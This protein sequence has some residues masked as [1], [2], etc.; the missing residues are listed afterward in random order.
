MSGRRFA[1]LC[2]ALAD[3]AHKLG[4][5]PSDDLLYNNL[6]SLF[7]E[8]EQL[9]EPVLTASMAVQAERLVEGIIEDIRLHTGDVSWLPLSKIHS[10]W[11]LTYLA[12]GPNGH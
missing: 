1:K 11:K 3:T 12:E 8:V 5:D 4:E 6:L 2:A 9:R 7:D 10:V